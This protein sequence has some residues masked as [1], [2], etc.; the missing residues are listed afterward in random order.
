MYEYWNDIQC[1]QNYDIG[2][3]MADQ[4]LLHGLLY[5]MDYFPN[6]VRAKTLF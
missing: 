1:M 6:I 2:M 3:L 4:P 5:Y